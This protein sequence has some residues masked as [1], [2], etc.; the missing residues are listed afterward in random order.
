MIE[1]ERKN[2]MLTQSRVDFNQRERRCRDDG[3]FPCPLEE[4]LFERGVRT[5]KRLVSGEKIIIIAEPKHVVLVRERG[6]GHKP[7]V[8]GQSAR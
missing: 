1:S 3:V 4:A 8:R 5:E 6:N 7:I 2:V